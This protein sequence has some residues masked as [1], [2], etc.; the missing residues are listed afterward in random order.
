MRIRIVFLHG[1]LGLSLHPAITGLPEQ[2]PV[3]DSNDIRLSVS[4]NKRHFARRRA[5]ITLIKCGLGHEIGN[6]RFGGLQQEQE[7]NS[8][9]SSC[10]GY[11]QR[12]SNNG[13]LSFQR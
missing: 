5:P 8:N 12:Y 11:G 4:M 1:E 10:V 9:S 2:V 7:H 3:K 6:V 13:Q